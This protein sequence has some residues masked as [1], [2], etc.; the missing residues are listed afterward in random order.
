M[1][2]GTRKVDTKG[3]ID[4]KTETIK[5]SLVS[6][7]HTPD[8]NAHDWKASSDLIDPCRYI[9]KSCHNRNK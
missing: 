3:K 5:V 4:F 7:K 8:Q 6:K 1:A 9:V 2:T